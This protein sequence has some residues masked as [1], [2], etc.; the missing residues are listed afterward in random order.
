MM[1][2]DATVEESRR[3]KM[4]KYEYSEFGVADSVSPICFCFVEEMEKSNFWNER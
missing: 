1:M 4:R 3:R 2:T